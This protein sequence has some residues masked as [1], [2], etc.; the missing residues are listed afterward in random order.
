MHAMRAQETSIQE[1][2]IF[3]DQAVVKLLSVWCHFNLPLHKPHVF[4]DKRSCIIICGSTMD[5]F[6][7]NKTCPLTSF[8]RFIIWP[9]ESCFLIALMFKLKL[10]LPL[11]KFT[12]QVLMQNHIFPKVALATTCISSKSIQVNGQGHACRGIQ[13]IRSQLTIQKKP[14]RCTLIS[15]DNI[16]IS[17]TQGLSS[18]QTDISHIN[19]YSIPNFF[20]ILSKTFSKI[21]YHFN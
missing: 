18:K 15:Y 16:R 11:H 13:R 6:S 1:S 10:G 19:F 4:I 17:I 7:Y 2:K 5:A 9:G 3:A 14:K 21:Y 8:Y 20:N 12:F